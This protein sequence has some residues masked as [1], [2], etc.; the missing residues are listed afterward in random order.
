MATKNL[1]DWVPKEGE[2]ALDLPVG[3]G[4]GNWRIVVYPVAFP[5]IYGHTLT[6]GALADPKV[7]K[8]LIDGLPPCHGRLA[9]CPVPP[10][11]TLPRYSTHRGQVRPETKQG[12][13]PVP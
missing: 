2:A 11:Q 13:P 8:Q 9:P 3:N 6:T 1:C 5:L 7:K 4:N 12:H 10:S